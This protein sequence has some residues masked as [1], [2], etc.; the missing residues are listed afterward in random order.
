DHELATPITGRPSKTASLKP[1]AFRYDRCMKPS[2]V[3][4]P[5]QLRLRRGVS[6]M[7]VS[8]DRVRQVRTSWRVGRPLNGPI[9]HAL[10]PTWERRRLPPLMAA[11]ALFRCDRHGSLDRR[12][13]ATL[14][15][16]RVTLALMAL[17]LTGCVTLAPAQQDS[18]AEVRIL[19]DRT[20]YLYALP[21]I[22]LLVTHNP[23][24]PP[25]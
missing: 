21:P 8:G 3:F 19:A 22:H 20:A 4:G 14:G 25:G 9:V 10:A 16:V 1:S 17:V 13:S 11:H 24:D 2:S 15:I 12:R 7:A 5:N 6:V 23:N 18:A